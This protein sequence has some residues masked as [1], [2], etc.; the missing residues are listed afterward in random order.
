MIFYLHKFSSCD[1]FVVQYPI[2]YYIARID[3]ENGDKSTA[4]ISKMRFFSSYTN[5]IS[6]AKTNKENPTEY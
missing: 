1:L 2:L 3:H 5:F 6:I 4:K